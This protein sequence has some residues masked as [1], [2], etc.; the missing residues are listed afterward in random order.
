MGVRIT[1]T[2][3]E[4]SEEKHSAS[5]VSFVFS[6]PRIAIGRSAGVDV[7][8][9]SAQVSDRHATIRF[10]G[11]TVSI[12]DESSTN[13]TYVAGTRIVALRAKVLRATETLTIGP[14]VLTVES[15][16]LGPRPTTSEETAIFAKQLARALLSP[17]KD[18]PKLRL[19]RRASTPPADATTV[20]ATQLAKPPVSTEIAIP[21]GTAVTIGR[22]DKCSL[23]IED[24]DASREHA[25]FLHREGRVTVRDLE[26]KNGVFVN[27]VR[28]NEARLTDGDEVRIGQTVFAFEDAAEA[29]L[30]HLGAT[31]EDEPQPRESIPLLQPP[32]PPTVA[33]VAER[34]H[35]PHSSNARATS[36]EPVP[37]ASVQRRPQKSAGAFSTELVV[38]AI[39]IAVGGASIVALYF[40]LRG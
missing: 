29:A 18:A 7:R 9:P 5:R 35:D 23:T 20:D 16:P 8:L 2:L 10:E 11:R 1:V 31:P 19:L 14:F 17:G 24:A 6:Q 15:Q 40:L 3:P 25:T 28:S 36:V 30:A 26:S 21:E 34:E 33:E 13:G 4:A 39:A 38:L 32:P 12:T 22:S 27:G 37:T